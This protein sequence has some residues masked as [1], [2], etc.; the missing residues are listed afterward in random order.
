MLYP[1]GKIL[2]QRQSEVEQ[3]F[4]D[5]YYVAHIQMSFWN[6]IRFLFQRYSC[7]AIYKQESR[8][9]SLYLVQIKSNVGLFSAS[10]LKSVRFKGNPTLDEAIRFSIEGK[11]IK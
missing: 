10:V 7:L 1:L 9:D 2:N 4:T 6:K 8:F 3:Q 11:V 5:F